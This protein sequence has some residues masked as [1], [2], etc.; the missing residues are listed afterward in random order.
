ME[1]HTD[2]NNDGF[3]LLELLVA[4]AIVGIL[5]NIAIPVF[6]TYRKQAKIGRTATEM[7]SFSSAFVAYL[8]EHGDYPPDSHRTLPPGMGKYINQ[9]HWDEETALGGFYNWEGPNNYGY[10]GLSI[11]GWSETPETLV[12]LDGMLD[13]GNPV[14]GRFRI[15]SNGRPTLIIAEEEDV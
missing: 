1:K 14:Q 7:K 13:D 8:A 2:I 15:G 12:L 5:V 4:L 3:T 6:E 9:R 11:F 10:A